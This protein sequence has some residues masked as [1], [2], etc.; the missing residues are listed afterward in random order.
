MA[1]AELRQA[2]LGRHA[3]PNKSGKN[4]VSSKDGRHGE[5]DEKAQPR[6][7]NE[8]ASL[9]RI[10]FSYHVA[11]NRLN[12]KQRNLN[13]ASATNIKNNVD[14]FRGQNATFLKIEKVKNRPKNHKFIKNS[15]KKNL[16]KLNEASKKN[17]KHN[18]KSHPSKVESTLTISWLVSRD[19]GS[20]KCTAS[21]LAGVTHTVFRVRVQG[22]CWCMYVCV[23]ACLPVG[24]SEGVFLDGFGMNCST[25]FSFFMHLL[26]LFKNLPKICLTNSFKFVL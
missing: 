11:D 9:K 13:E 12:I 15:S 6:E 2:S 16:F 8:D 4:A 5:P 24:L 19:S 1:G 17:S 25:C 14:H 18:K 23:P 22:L 3:D 7:R 21:N 10:H 26:L 20:Y